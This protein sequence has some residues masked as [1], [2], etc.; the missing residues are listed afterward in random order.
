MTRL[1]LGRL[2]EIEVPLPDPMVDGDGWRY[3]MAR[4]RDRAAE[5]GFDAVDVTRCAR[6]ETLARAMSRYDGV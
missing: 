2:L 1:G 5:F 6:D 3:V 4:C